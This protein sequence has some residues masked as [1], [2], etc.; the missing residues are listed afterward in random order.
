MADVSNTGTTIS[1]LKIDGCIYDAG[2]YVIEFSN[3]HICL[4]FRVTMLYRLLYFP[5]E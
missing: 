2:V 3:F 5:S 1:Y 4:Y